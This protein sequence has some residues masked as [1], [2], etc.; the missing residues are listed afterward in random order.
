MAK[1][2]SWYIDGTF[3]IVKDPIKQLLTIHVV[4]VYRQIKR[5]SIPVCFILMT[6]R[7]KS[8]YVKVLNFIKNHCNKYLDEHN[9]TN[10][11]I[12]IMADFEIA[13]WQAIREIRS[14]SNSNFRGDLQIKGC[15]FHLTQAIF[16]KVIQNNLQPEYYH[17]NNSGLRIYIK[18][19]MALVLLPPNL[20]ASTFQLIYDK[21]KTLNCQD[22]NNLFEYFK[23]T[24]VTN[25]NWSVN[26]I[27]QW[28]LRIRTNND[29][30]RFHMKLMNSVNR[31]NIEFYELIN[32][33]GDIGNMIELTTTM[34]AQGMIES[35]QKK[36]Q[37]SFEKI[38]TN[39][40]NDL[41]DKKIT[42]I[43]FLNLLTTTNHDNQLVNHDWGVTNSRIDPLP[44]DESDTE[45]DENTNESDESE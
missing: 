29:S 34:F 39:A 8:D 3:K 13:L 38:L 22:L 16:R 36:K 25:S 5:V 15:Y 32:I 45:N 19:L 9:L 24:W 40:S 37:V 20:I 28:R 7:R 35:K 27:C 26:E 2:H 21:V 10:N 31:S 43:E 4:L 33:L 41:Y 44:E 11:L 17:K 14:Q 18:W 1:A 23:K 12:K 30:E 6:R 42:P